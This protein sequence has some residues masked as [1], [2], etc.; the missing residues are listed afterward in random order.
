MKKLIFLTGEDMLDVDL[1]IVKEINAT[2]NK[3]F[4]LIW[5]V[6]LRGYGWFK[7]DEMQAFCQ[8]NNIQCVILEQIG[9]LKNPKTILFTFKL[10]KILKK[11]NADII[12]DS[13]L[14]VP[15]MHFLRPLYL[16]KELFVVA[17][18]DVVQHHKMK[19]KMVR[20]FYYTFLMKTYLNFHIF[21]E[22]QLR[23][24]KGKFKGK[25]SFCTPLYLK[26]F[27]AVVQSKLPKNKD[28][29]VFLFFGIIRANKGLDILI[30]AANS[31]G[32]EHKNFHVVI[33]G[34]SD[35]WDEYDGMIRYPEQFTLH[36]GNVEK[37]KVPELFANAHFLVLPYR[38]V[39]Q[40]GVLLTAYN[41]NVPVI[42]TKLEWFEEYVE[43]T[44]NG[45]LFENDNVKDLALKMAAAIELNQSNY[46]QMVGSLK[47]FIAQK[48]NIKD[49]AEEYVKFF[50]S[51]NNHE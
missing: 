13:Y 17:I 49:I 31:L 14:G 27:G 25:R 5:V 28:T 2:N 10:L 50:K 16:K 38:D 40:S 8:Q 46:N 45:Y 20:T 32:E 36:I 43:D 41:Y 33:A 39:T 35:N 12:Y 1:P 48:I 47:S 15:Y 18:H 7:K 44:V 23:I 30:E 26:N 4:H 29:T 34:K 22:N 42:A 3:D 37:E 51:I 9:K 21:S 19:D 11:L 6:V 24:F